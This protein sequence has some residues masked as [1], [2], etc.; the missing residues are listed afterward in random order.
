MSSIAIH[1]KTYEIHQFMGKVEGTSK[2]RETRVH[3]GGGG[4]VVRNGQGATAPVRIS[5][6]TTVHDNFFLLNEESNAEKDISLQ[7]WDV[8]LREGH[9]VQVI[10]VIPPKSNAGPYVVVNN[11]NLDK[12]TWSKP[13][14]QR[15]AGAHYRGPLWGS[16]AVAVIPAILF[17]SFLV[18]IV[19]GI[20]AA[21]WWFKK[22]KEVA[23]E[24]E[25][26][27]SKQLL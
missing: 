11:K 17:K 10:W 20:A 7:N 12:V 6:T 16:L 9:K 18:L 21:F 8:A 4:G 15:I 1:N 3:G 5:S 25:Q 13:T 24:L 26:A 22:I 14:I 2:Q 27:V 19:L 23:L